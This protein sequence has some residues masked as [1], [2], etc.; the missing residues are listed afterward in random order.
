MLDP[1][2]FIKVT[3]GQSRAGFPVYIGWQTN[4]V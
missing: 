4:I 1:A 3:N 2:A